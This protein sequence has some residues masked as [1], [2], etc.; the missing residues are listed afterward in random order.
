MP[1]ITINNVD[2]NKRRCEISRMFF[3]FVCYYTVMC[4]K[5]DNKCFNT[6]WAL[7]FSNK[8]KVSNISILLESLKY[9][10]SVLVEVGAAEY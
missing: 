4:H 10:L 6:T 9:Q 7:E 1:I 3:L 8:T 5:A 2:I